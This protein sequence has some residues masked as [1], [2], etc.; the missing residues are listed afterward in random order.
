METLVLLIYIVLIRALLFLAERKL[1]EVV[2]WQFLVAFIVGVAL[3]VPLPLILIKKE[4]LDNS[5][6]NVLLSGLSFFYFA[7]VVS[8]IFEKMKRF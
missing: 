8:R 3:S 1:P 7:F 5:I 4:I 6:Q 2:K